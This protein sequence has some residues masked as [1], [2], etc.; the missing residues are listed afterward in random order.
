MIMPLLDDLGR[1][2]GNPSPGGLPLSFIERYFGGKA[3]Q[4]M[5]HQ[6]DPNTFRDEYYYNTRQNV[7]YR[8]VEA[9]AVGCTTGSSKVWKAISER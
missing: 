4:M 7:L 1:Y 2:R 3:I 8:K 5:F 9:P 6:P